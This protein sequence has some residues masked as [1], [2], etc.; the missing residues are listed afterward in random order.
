MFAR[1]TVGAALLTLLTTAITAQRKDLYDLDTVREIRLYFKQS[2]Y[3]SLMQQNYSSKTNIE[4]D[5]K[6]DGITYPRVGVRFRGNTSYTR[7]PRG[8][9]KFGFNIETDFVNAGQDLYGYEHL[10]LNNGYHD[11]TFMREVITYQICR[12]YMCAPKA[13][14]VKV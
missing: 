11:P 5:M 12:R 6:V 7:I 9:Q 4:A 3:W 1:F 8:S 10:N 14:F 2:N 13:N